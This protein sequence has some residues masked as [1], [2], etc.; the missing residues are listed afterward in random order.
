M[1]VLDKLASSLGRRDEV[2][3]KELALLIADKNDKKAI[4]E[5]AENLG[6]KN[7]E[8]QSDCIKTLYEVGELKPVLVAPYAKDFIAL[9][10]SKNNRLQW[11]AM[12]ALSSIA[13]ENPKDVYAALAK[14]VAVAD[15][16]TVITKD[17]CVKILVKLCALKQYADTAFP[18][19]AEQIL[20]SPVN[21][22]PTYAENAMPYV[23]EEDKAGF[24]SMLKSRVADVTTDTKKK[25]LEKVI[26]KLSAK[27]KK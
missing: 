17:H 6:N 18:L 10:D 20:N 3:N 14:I 21:Q 12:T 4:A 7:K 15:K 16:G 24:I 11:G 1:S 22:L 5:L 13:A 25:R 9:L 19:L 2:P 27:G 26:E 23:K 8:I